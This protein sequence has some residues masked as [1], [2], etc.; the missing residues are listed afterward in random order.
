MVRTRS[1]PYPATIFPRQKRVWCQHG[2]C[3][4][5]RHGVGWQG[6]YPQIQPNRRVDTPLGHPLH[7]SNGAQERSRSLGG[8]NVGAFD[9]DPHIYGIRALKSCRARR[10]RYSISSPG[11]ASLGRRRGTTRRR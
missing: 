4:H 11:T 9:R 5:G 2:T 6:A 8:S 3:Q 10:Y 7:R 1:S